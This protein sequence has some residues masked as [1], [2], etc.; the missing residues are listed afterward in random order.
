MP[1][2]GFGIISTGQT[3]LGLDKFLAYAQTSGHLTTTLITNQAI[4]PSGATGTVGTFNVTANS[5]ARAVVPGGVAPAFWTIVAGANWTFFDGGGLFEGP[6]EVNCAGR[7]ASGV[8][9]RAEYNTFRCFELGFGGSLPFGFSSI[10]VSGAGI[11]FQMAADR[12]TPSYGM[13]TFQFYDMYGTYVAQ[14]Q[15]TSIDTEDGTWAK[16]WTN[17]LTGLPT[18]NYTV[19]LINATADGTGERVGLASTYLYGAQSENYI[20][21]NQFFVS[22]QYYDLL[23]RGPDAGGLSGWTNEITQCSNVSFRQPYETYAQCVIRRRV[24]VSLGFWGSQE[25]LQLH[26][27]VINSSGSTTYDHSQFV[28]L[29]HVFYLRREPTQA[30]QDFWMA[31]L[32]GTE[33]Y[34]GVIKGF[35]NSDEYRLRFEPPPP[36]PC[37]PPWWEVGNCQ[38]Q[39]GYWDY[40]DCRCY[41]AG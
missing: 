30:E 22:Q 2:P 17:C 26:P 4:I 5:K 41:Y 15:A 23:N 1:N 13:P 12:V 25:F 7:T 19:Q 31:H 39:P 35:I 10:N 20:D 36:E 14:T 21:D 3:Q 29:C 16:G 24:D 28:R 33:D 38:Q 32:W 34:G 6:H 40:N 27:E 9:N 18:G 8:M 11:E 37:N